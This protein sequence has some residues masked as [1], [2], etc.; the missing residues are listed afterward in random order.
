MM[1]FFLIQRLLPAILVLLYAIIPVD[2][3]PDFLGPLGRAD[4]LLLFGL[5]AWYLMSRKSLREFLKFGARPG[6]GQRPR[7]SVGDKPGDQSG[8]GDQNP[9]TIL[10]IAPNASIEDIRKA[11]RQKVAQYHPDRVNH[12]GEELQ[13]LAHRKFIQIKKAYED[14]LRRRGVTP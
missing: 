10:E 4:D 2:L 11:Y 5:L 1:P 3:L 6:P 9:Y 13:K 8:P 14:I 12:L 7:E